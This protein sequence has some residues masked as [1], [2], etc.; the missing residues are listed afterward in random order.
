M[1]MVSRMRVIRKTAVA[2]LFYPEDPTL[3]KQSIA[4][5]L[6]L[7]DSSEA[8]INAVPKA[9][10]APHAGYIYS[11]TAAAKAYQCIQ[12]AHS[13]I[14]RV[15]LLGPSHRVGFEGIAFCSSDMF[16]TPLGNIPVDHSAFAAI[17][18]LPG[19]LLLDQAHAQEHSLEVQLPF[20]QS[21]LDDFV[22]VPLVVGD[23]SP[24][25][26]AGVLDK[27]WG[28]QETLI[29]ISS[30]LSHFLQYAAANLLDRQTC[31]A[32]EQLHPEDIGYEQ[33]CGRIPIKG[34]LELA[35]SK[36]LKVRTLMLCNSGDTAGDKQRVVG[37][38]SWA[39]YE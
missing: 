16:N 3:L 6:A 29:V 35:Q 27:L 12:P 18:D 14:K 8:R 10:I 34:L 9:I 24:H 13:T 7:S 17:S 30:D 25:H 22:L 21:V 26:V 1:E 33:A 20:L 37:Y 4:K 28:E 23:A 5:F 31:Q 38:G 11:G 19:V 15:V 39:F 36:R 32:V 2:G